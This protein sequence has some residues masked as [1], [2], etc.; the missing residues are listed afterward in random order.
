VFS[1]MKAA[2]AKGR[3]AKVAAHS[4]VAEDKSL[5]K[6]MVKP[7]ALTGRAAGGKVHSKKGGGK[8][9]AKTAVNIVI[10]PRAGG[11]RPVPVPVP[12]SG[13]G[14][15]PAPM[16]SRAPVSPPPSVSP[17]VGA[18][19]GPRQMP[20]G[21]GPMAKGGAVKKRANGGKVFDAG[22]ATGVGREEKIKA[23]GKKAR[24]SE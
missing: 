22:A 9:K 2:S 11:D 21:A 7:D 17:G 14:A 15:G 6:K 4:D 5:V 23:Y 18:L 8:G 12:A 13:A 16:P 20:P 1:K 3:A 10:A 19:A 24:V